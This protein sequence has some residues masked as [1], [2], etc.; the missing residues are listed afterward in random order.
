MG[1]LL[2]LLLLYVS[3]FLCLCLTLV[4]DMFL[5]VTRWE[6][7]NKVDEVKSWMKWNL[8]YWNLEIVRVNNM[9][10]KACKGSNRLHFSFPLSHYSF[11]LML[12]IFRPCELD[13]KQNLIHMYIYAERVGALSNDESDREH[14]TDMLSIEMWKRNFRCMWWRNIRSKTKIKDNRSYKDKSQPKI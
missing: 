7:E 2:C 10:I 11:S 12:M 1:N 14:G 6:P 5:F 13:S 4:W 3:V 8:Y 9:K